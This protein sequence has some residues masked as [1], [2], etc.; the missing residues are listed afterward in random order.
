MSGPRITFTLVKTVTLDPIWY[1]DQWHQEMLAEGMTEEE[2]LREIVRE[3]VEE[4]ATTILFEMFG[5]P[6]D[7]LA[8]EFAKATTNLHLT[9]AS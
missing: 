8:E 7:G 6:Q 9:D 1:D 2:A 4:D 3:W 5:T